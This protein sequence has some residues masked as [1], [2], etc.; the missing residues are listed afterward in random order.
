MD[1]V[2]VPV[3]ADEAGVEPTSPD[4]EVRSETSGSSVQPNMQITAGAGTAAAGDQ[5]S[6]EK[7]GTKN[8]RVGGEVE[9]ERP[10]KQL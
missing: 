7:A 9:D 3:L 2:E 4:S 1:T 5:G 10:S 6:P 8:E